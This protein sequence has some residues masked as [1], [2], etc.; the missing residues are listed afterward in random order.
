MRY[1]VL[2]SVVIL[3]CIILCSFTVE[4]SEIISQCK[5]AYTH[6]KYRAIVDVVGNHL[7]GILIINQQPDSSHR[8]VFVNE[9]GV[10]FFDYTFFENRY[11]VNQIMKSL[12]KK[13]VVKT[14]AKDFGMILF[15]G[16]YKNDQVVSTPTELIYTL[17]RKGSVSYFLN[18]SVAQVSKIVNYSKSKPIVTIQQYYAN[19]HS[20]PDSMF[21][22]H[23]TF[24]FTISLKKIHVTE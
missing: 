7:S 11:V 18:D 19:Q 1:S 23:H 2:N 21:V 9:I 22:Q 17:K 3:I 20:I 12:N 8:V 4:T 15:K 6:E 14:L 5:P 16:I 13:A 24:N 10:T